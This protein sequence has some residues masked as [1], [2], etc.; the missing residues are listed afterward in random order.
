MATRP[1]LNVRNNNPLN[2]RFSKHNNWDGQIGQSGGFA[3]FETPEY[4]FRAAYKLI[5]RY[6]EVY[7]LNSLTDI[8]ARWAP[9][10]ENDSD[11]YAEF[12][13]AKLDK[14]TWTPVFDSEIPELLFYMAQ[15]EGAQ[16]AFTMDQ[17]NGGIALA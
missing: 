16:G 4:G 3:K 11:A 1:N 6:R 15:Y 9:E 5:Q 7:G 2:I 17:V 12:L 14:F 13:A 8:V 10:H